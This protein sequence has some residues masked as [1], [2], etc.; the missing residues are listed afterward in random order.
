VFLFYFVVN[1]SRMLTLVEAYFNYRQ[2][3][4]VF[5]MVLSFLNP[6][7][8]LSPGRCNWPNNTV[9]DVFVNYKFTKLTDLKSPFQSIDVVEF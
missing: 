7:K 4:F 6:V 3:G 5:L 8:V 2:T 1:L 9:S